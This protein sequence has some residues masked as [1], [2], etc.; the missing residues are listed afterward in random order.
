MTTAQLTTPDQNKALVR[1]VFDEIATGGDFTVVD[2]LYTEDY[3]DHAPFPGSPGGRGDVRHSIGALRTAL[4]DLHVTVQEMSAYGDKVATHNTWQGTHTGEVLGIDPTG[5]V[6]TFAGVVVFRV[7][8]GKIAERWAIGLELDLLK[9]L[10]LN[11]RWLRSR[12]G[13]SGRRG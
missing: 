11:F 2:D 4:P 3:V 5:R 8:G 6:L 1:R 12:T 13:G 10:G 7:A 9:E